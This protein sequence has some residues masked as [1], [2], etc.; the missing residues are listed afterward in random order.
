MKI[1][2]G[3]YKPTSGKVRSMIKETAFQK[4]VFARVSPSEYKKL[5]RHLADNGMRLGDWVSKKIKEIKQ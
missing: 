2:Q 1:K 3:T 5:K 4:A